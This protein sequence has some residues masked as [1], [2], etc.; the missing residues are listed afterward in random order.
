MREVVYLIEAIR[1]RNKIKYKTEAALH[2]FQ[3]PETQ[4]S[5]LST[6]NEELTEEMKIKT[7][8]AIKEATQRK[9]REIAL[10]N[11]RG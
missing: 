11:K 7:D 2:G 4:T 6:E 9:I 5:D 10:R 3:V 8:L 1:Q